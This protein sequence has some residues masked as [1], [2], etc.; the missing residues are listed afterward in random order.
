M[1]RAHIN[2]ITQEI[3]DLLQSGSIEVCDHSTVC[4]SPIKCVAKKG[5]DKHRLIIDLCQVNKF[6][7]TPK[8]K[9]DI[10]TVIEKF[11]YNDQLISVDLKNGFN[12]ILIIPE[13]R[14]YL[15]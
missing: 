3:N 2:F 11:E 1:T 4:I 6:L 15:D 9:Y 7:T 14:D 10:N 13:D 5:Q 8:F 12:H